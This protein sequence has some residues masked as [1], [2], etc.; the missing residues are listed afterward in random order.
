MYCKSCG[1]QVPGSFR[2]CP[3]CGASVDGEITKEGVSPRGGGFHRFCVSTLIVW[4]GLW[5]GLTIAAIGFLGKDAEKSSG[6]ML[7]LG[8]GLGFYALL[9]FLP[10]LILGVMAIATKLP[11]S[12]AWP[13][14]TKWIT[15]ALASLFFLLPQLGRLDRMH[16]KIK[17]EKETTW[18]LHQQTSDL[19]GS[20]V[21]MLNLNAKNQI[22]GWLKAE[23][24]TLII[25]CK[26]GKTDAYVVSNM[27]ANPE[28]GKFGDY[29]IRFKVDDAAP[30]KET[31]SAST[32]ESALFSPSPKDFAK[33]LSGA[34]DLAF[35]FT[36]FQSSPATAHFDVRGLDGL[37]EKVA[38]PCGWGKAQ[39]A[40]QAQQLAAQVAAT[41]EEKAAKEEQR[42]ARE[43]EHAQM[44]RLHV[45]VGAIDSNF[46]T[47]HYSAD[48]EEDKEVDLGIMVTSKH[49]D[50]N[51]SVK[52]EIKWPEDPANLKVFVNG[53]ALSPSAWKL[54]KDPTMA[55]IDP[56]SNLGAKYVA[57]ILAP[58]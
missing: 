29:S 39:E 22:Q 21:V 46:V 18:I 4:T 20:T 34:H 5:G 49:I 19:D 28:Y 2:F 30:A 25:R 27:P 35:E 7:G 33:R 36:P 11:E 24:P 40:A 23:T 14:A 55:K 45:E 58:Q 51:K 32:D 44:W 17:S 3:Q 43:L 16:P 15:I 13:R 50:G 9:W 8:L 37:L 12:V 41:A 1:T 26:E 38:V 56:D 57:L 10:S 31:W 54:A 47:L 6:V 42:K 48:L 52:L 53:A